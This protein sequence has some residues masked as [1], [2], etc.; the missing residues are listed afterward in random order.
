VKI[1]DKNE[2]SIKTIGN[3][4]PIGICGSGLLETLGELTRLNK[5]NHVGRLTEDEEKY[6]LNVENNIFLNENDINLLAQTK[7]ANIAALKIIFK[8][9]GIN[10]NEIDTFYLAGGFGEHIDIEACIRIG[11]LPNISLNKFQ[12]IGNATI[13]GLTIAL[14][15]TSK[16]TKLNAFVKKMNQINLETDPEFFDHF[17]DGCLF[18][19]IN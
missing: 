16:R 15:S 2:I 8:E 5:I 7:A 17:V 12:K 3:K 4:K 14:L 10:F 9:Y 19:E 11:L 13:E 18:Q 1:N 6:F